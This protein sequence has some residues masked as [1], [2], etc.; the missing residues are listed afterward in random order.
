MTLIRSASANPASISCSTKP[1]ANLSVSRASREIMPADSAG[2]MPAIGSSSSRS[3]GGVAS[4]MAISSARFSPCDK[5]PAGS[6]ARRSRPTSANAANPGSRSR[7]SCRA[8]FQKR[9]LCPDRACAASAILSSAVNSRKIEVIWN[10]RAIPSMARRAGP[11]RDMSVPAKRIVPASGRSSPESSAIR[12]VWP[13]PFGPITASSSPGSTESE[14]SLVAVRPPKRLVSPSISSSALAI[15]PLPPGNQAEQT[16]L[17]K[18]HDQDQDRPERGLPV[19]GQPRQDA[20]Q[21]QVGRRA[22]DRPEQRADAA[23]DH[24]HHDLARARPMHDRGRDE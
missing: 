22:E 23:E 3:R 11:S 21:D 20:L 18:Q 8:G 17:R 7:G 9:K 2:P 10:E 5:A 1:I 4:A 6:P 14:T 13:A 16:G 15:A 19:L 24:H 12:V